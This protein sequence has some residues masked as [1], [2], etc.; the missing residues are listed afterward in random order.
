MCSCKPRQRTSGHTS[1]A[2][3]KMTQC[4]LRR[5]GDAWHGRVRA[6]VCDQGD[7]HDQATPASGYTAAVS[8]VIMNKADDTNVHKKS[9]GRDSDK[10][11]E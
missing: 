7:M 9:E 10:E 5:K 11:N 6:R 1:L 3:C 8:T 2:A 4:L